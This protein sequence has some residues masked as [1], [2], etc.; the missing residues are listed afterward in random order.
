VLFPL[1]IPFAAR[2]QIGVGESRLL[3]ELIG[4]P[5]GNEEN[6]SRP[7]GEEKARPQH[8]ETVI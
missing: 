5:G 4:A 7:R 1:R 8:R 3:G 2:E 6:Q